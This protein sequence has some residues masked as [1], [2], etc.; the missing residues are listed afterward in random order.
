MC[1]MG[2][3]RTH[4]CRAPPRGML[5]QGVPQTQCRDGASLFPAGGPKPR[6]PG[7]KAGPGE[8]GG[9]RNVPPALMERLRP[10]PMCF[11]WLR[12]PAC[13]TCFSKSR[14]EESQAF[15]RLLVR[16]QQTRIPTMSS[17]GRLLAL[18]TQQEVTL[19]RQHPASSS[20]GSSGGSTQDPALCL[21]PP[22]L[23]S[24]HP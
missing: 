1:S 6:A 3:S 13:K 18:S 15:L 24:Q 10:Q 22:A 7:E 9:E 19:C 21:S 12:P 2:G 4:Q 16:V 5:R 11:A 14:Q 17:P 23:S 8:R 20:M